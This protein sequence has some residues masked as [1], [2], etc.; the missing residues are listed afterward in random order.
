MMRRRAFIGLG[1]AGLISCASSRGEYFGNTAPPRNPRYYDAHMVGLDELTFLPVVDGTTAVNLYRSGAVAT[2]PGFSFPPVFTPIL[3]RKKDFHAEPAFGTVAPTISAL[4]PPLDNVLLRYALNMGT[5]KKPFT[6]L[7]GGSRIP[8]SNLVPPV[9]DYPRPDTLQVTV[10][11]TSYDVLS[12]NLEGARAL[13]AKAGFDAVSGCGRRTLE[14]TYHFPALPD[15]NLKAQMLQQQ[16]QL[17][18]GI[19]VRLVVREFSVHWKMVIEGDYSGVADYAF[20]MTYFDP[21]A[22]LDLFLTPGVGNPTGWTDPGYASML[23]D[24]NRTLNPQERMTKL[25]DCEKVLL[26]GM[27]IVPLYFDALT[28][29]QKPFVKGLASNPF[30]IRAFKYARIDTRWRPQ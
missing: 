8:A 1:A 15:T 20:L 27:P 23:A 9:P 11:G 16:W 19:R 24:A 12:F 26:R 28:Y 14:I 25:A 10:D 29:L 4:K 21:N 13:L 2:M 6:D 30:D 17:N 7:L 22:Y 18:L 3:G 5:E